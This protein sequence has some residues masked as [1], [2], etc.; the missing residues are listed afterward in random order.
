VVTV[1]GSTTSRLY[2]SGRKQGVAVAELVAAGGAGYRSG[3][4]R[5]TTAGGHGHL[6]GCSGAWRSRPARTAGRGGAGF[7]TYAH[8][9]GASD[10]AIAR[11]TRHRSLA[12]L[13]SY[14][15]VQQA[16]TDNAATGLGL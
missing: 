16:W 12:T 1:G 14:V 10:R 8:L 13:G 2:S 5:L 7:V 4:Q 9:R 11:Q 15:R 6:A 3:D